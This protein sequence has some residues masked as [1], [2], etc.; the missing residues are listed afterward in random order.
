MNTR[1]LTASAM[2]VSLGVVL[3]NLIYIPVGVSKCFPIQHTINILSSIVLGPFYST[4]IA[5]LISLIRNILGTGSLLAFPG[6][7][8]GAF[9]A[10]IIYKKTENKYLTAIG[11]VFGT[12]ILGGLLAF[13]IAKYIMGKE[14]LAFF[15]VYPFI[16]STS[17]GAIMALILIKILET[18]KEKQLSL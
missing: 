6:S 5:F 16:L 4:I 18:M 9:L 3:G 17:G 11:E 2:F 8:I 1:K 15:F 12:G 10:G 7:M 13:P 14:V